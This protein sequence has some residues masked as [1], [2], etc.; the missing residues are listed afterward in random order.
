MRALW[1]LVAMLGCTKTDPVETGAPSTP[2]DTDTEPVTDTEPPDDTADTAPADLCDALGLT[3]RP[4]L[5]EGA[6][7]DARR[8]LADDFTLSTVDGDWSFFEQYTGCETYVFVTD[9]MPTSPLDSSPIVHDVDGLVELLEKSPANAR[10]FFLTYQ[11]DTAAW[12]TEMT[13][14]LAEALSLV[15]ADVA[16]ALADRLHVVDEVATGVEPWVADALLYPTEGFAIDRFQRL[17]ELGSLADVNRY[18]ATLN[19]AGQWPWRDNVAYVAHMP[20]IFN[21]ESDLDDDA[22]DLDPIYVLYDDPVWLT[23]NDT[24]DVTFPDAA[25]MAATDTLLVDLEHRCDPAQMEYGNCDAWDAIQTL[26][27]CQP[28]NPDTCDIELARYITTYHREGRW[29]ADASQLLP[30]LVDGGTKRLHLA[31]IRGGH[32]ITLRLLLGARDGGAPLSIEPLWTGGS[33][34]ADYDANHPPITV[35]VPAE[36]TRAFL[37]VNVTGHGFGTGD[38]C[39]EFCGHE[40][41]FTIGDTTWTADNWEVYDTEGCLKQIG[42]GAVPNQY[43]TWWYGRS[44]WC[45]GMQVEPWVFEITDAITPGQPVT[46]TYTTNEGFVTGGNIEL[47]SYVAFWK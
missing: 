24:W 33:F 29:L 11:S 12:A 21:H 36:A 6:F 37:N 43:G 22:A 23:G 45:P 18:D 39:A 14:D 1:L 16:E 10:Y 4:L 41:H 31:G 27:L 26:Y 3:R 19:A 25:T 40:H 38:N 34:N 15:D 30:Y 47:R 35:D 2:E 7:G 28:D 32:Y 8:D 20:Q 17:R 42:D 44:S 13:D 46:I 5:A 9:R